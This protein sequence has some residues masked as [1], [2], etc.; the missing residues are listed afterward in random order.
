[1]MGRHGVDRR[2][3]FTV[4]SSP[5][6]RE[7]PTATP[8]WPMSKSLLPDTRFGRFMRVVGG[9]VFVMG[10]VGIV[11]CG[12]MLARLLLGAGFPG[13]ST[14]VTAG[15]VVI[16]VQSSLLCHFGFQASRHR[17]R[18]PGWGLV[19]LVAL[20]WIPPLLILFA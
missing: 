14:K 15:Y 11:F 7:E 4:S 3:L 20:S 8:S 18:V 17:R 6:P 12:W 19:T 5:D 16:L 2:D 10:S 13:A 1:M 9:I